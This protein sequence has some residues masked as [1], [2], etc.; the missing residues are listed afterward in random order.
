MAKLHIHV[1]D[2]CGRTVSKF[3]VGPDDEVEFFNDH[4]SKT[5]R[6][7]I[8][9]DPKDGNALCCGGEGIDTFTVT[10]EERRRAFSIC[11]TYAPATFKYTATLSGSESEDPI[12]II[13]RR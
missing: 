9:T 6:I 7:S 12:I 1:D 5:L 3:G 8:Q 11:R 4:P 13:E 2:H 10:P